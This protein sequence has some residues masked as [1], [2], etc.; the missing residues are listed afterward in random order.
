M[1]SGFIERGRVHDV[2]RLSAPQEYESRLAQLGEFFGKQSH[3][4]VPACG[5]AVSAFSQRSLTSMS[6]PERY[7]SLAHIRASGGA[8]QTKWRPGP[9][10]GGGVHPPASVTHRQPID[11]GHGT[12]L[13]VRRANSPGA[14]LD[15]YPVLRQHGTRVGMALPNSQVMSGPKIRPV[16]PLAPGVTP[17][18]SLA[19]CNLPRTSRRIWDR[20]GPA[21]RPR[22][23]HEL[24][25]RPTHAVAYA[26][27]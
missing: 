25:L 15:A 24:G 27:P 8:A 3:P 2:A 18:W 6:P 14:P 16:M 10:A 4:L 19:R 11:T 12:G 13:I 9:G 5:I 21:P 17:Q 22:F 26:M 7:A 23:P 20:G 1:G